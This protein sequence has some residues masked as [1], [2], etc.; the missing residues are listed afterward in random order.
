MDA[1]SVQ[2]FID[3]LRDLSATKFV[4]SGFT[5][6]EFAVTVTSNDGKRVEKAEFAKVADGYIARREN[7]PALYQLDGKSVDD[8]LEASKAV[9]PASA[10]KKK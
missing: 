9:K 8:M 4:T 6:P 1:G 10:G 2:A 7:E 5:T 3:K